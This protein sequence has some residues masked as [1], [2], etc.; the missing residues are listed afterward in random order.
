MK[1]TV[2][3]KI[4]AMILTLAITISLVPAVTINAAATDEQFALVPGGIYYFNLSA[5]LSDIQ[6]DSTA[7]INTAL[8]DGSLKW[9]PFTYAGTVNAYS[10]AAAGVSTDANVA[11]GSRSLF[12]SDYAV[13][14]NVSWDGLNSK[15][16]IFG[17]AGGN[18]TAN[19]INYNLRSLS[20]GSASNGQSGNAVR[21]IPQSNEWDQVLDKN[22]S[23]IKYQ[24]NIF[25]WGQDTLS[26]NTSVRVGRS[27]GFIR[28]FGNNILTHRA[29]N[30]DGFRPALEILNTDTLGPDGLKTVT[31]DMGESGKIGSTASSLTQA[32]VV[33][34][35]A[36][37]LPAVT[38]ANGFY[39]TGTVQEGMT[40]GWLDSSGNLYAAGTSLSLP[41]GTTLTAGYGV[42]GVT[43]TPSPIEI[44][45]GASQQ[46]TA[47]VSGSGTYS[48]A[49]NWTVA[50]ASSSGTT[51][52]ASGLLT[53]A[54]DET[55][56][57]LTVKAASAQTESKFGTAAVTVIITD[58][59][60]LATPVILLPTDGSTINTNLPMFTGTAE[61]GSTVTI[62]L[63]GNS[64]GT[65]TADAAGNW[66]FTPA[67]ALADGAHNVKTT[68]TDAAGNASTD[69][70][71]STFTV[72]TAPPKQPA[73][74]G[75][76]SVSTSAP[77]FLRSTSVSGVEVDVSALALP[78]DVTLISKDFSGLPTEAAG[79]TWTL[80][81]TLSG[82]NGTFHGRGYLALYDFTLTDENG[83]PVTGYLGRVTV[84]L[85]I[86]SGST[87]TPHVLYY[88][89]TNK[90]F[91]EIMSIPNNGYLTYS[92]THFN[93]YL[94][95]GSG[96]TGEKPAIPETGASAF[97]IAAMGVILLLTLTVLLMVQT[98]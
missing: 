1:K 16:L 63:D 37:T 94:I 17:D 54:A 19:G 87:G 62:I 31:Y 81:N 82:T 35:G 95:T 49:V 52:D 92:T 36:L 46:F 21:G 74:S 98:R 86:P 9:V 75:T 29:G 91:A 6:Y 45:K 47:T 38:E 67:A 4:M 2:H 97:P 78:A 3:R 69:S 84:R 68:A 96:N 53:I 28:Y 22:S 51:I 23:Y 13:S 90:Q 42:T 40:L 25:C 14:T 5:K 34:T 66:S 89:E 59:T 39:Y 10:R 44:E 70:N 50:G 27:W 26:T 18:Y 88:D 64:A 43:V 15:G 71:V 72:D 7:A 30:D 33:Y 20:T 32:S 85:P 56:S 55:A 41:T 12:V 61:A 80:S 8:P 76:A 93:H 73:S 79:K 57:T 60:P 65:T 24:A 83:K 48:H 77:V 58:T 11:V